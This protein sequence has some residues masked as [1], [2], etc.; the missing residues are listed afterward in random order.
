MVAYN[1]NER[2]YSH[3]EIRISLKKFEL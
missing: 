2:E 1:K 3:L